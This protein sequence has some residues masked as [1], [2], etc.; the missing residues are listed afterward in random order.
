MVA[1]AEGVEGW[2]GMVGQVKA[3][4][5]WKGLVMVGEGALQLVEPAWVLLAM[6]VGGKN[7]AGEAGLATTAA[8]G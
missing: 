1:A 4:V 7:P 8:A 2:V 6:A 3:V 5:G